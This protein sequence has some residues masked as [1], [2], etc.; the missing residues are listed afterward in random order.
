MAGLQQQ[1]FTVLDDKHPTAIVAFH[2]SGETNKADSPLQGIV[3]V[4]A[5]NTPFQG[6]GY[7]RQELAKFLRQD[8]GQLPIPM[9]LIFF[10]D[11]SAQIQPVAT[12]DGNALAESLNSN[13]SGLRVI[14]R[15]Q[16]FYGATE[17]VEMSLRTVE[18]LA[19]Y[20]AK[21][22]GRK[23]VVWLSPGWPLLSGPNVSLTEKDQQ[24]LFNTI[25]TLS[26]ELREARVTLY[27]IDPRGAEDAASPNQLYYQEFLKGVGAAEKARSGNLALQVLAV[28]SGGRAL[29]SSN[30]IANSIKSCLEDAKAF[31]TISFDAAPADGPNEYHS[32]QVKIGKAG[33]TART[34]TGYYAQ[35]YRR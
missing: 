33:L 16:G 13:Q 18:E 23:L 5:V 15:S 11:A 35:P 34:R 17:R 25:V 9:S 2:A 28:Q 4:D 20:E 6:V 12:R 19:T 1:D 32:L 3:L 22:P 29:T 7:Q 10:T 30:D 31:Y 27:S 8:G 21:Q 24:G 14:G 26:D